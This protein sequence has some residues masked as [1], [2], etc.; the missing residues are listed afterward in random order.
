MNPYKL[1]PESYGDKNLNAYFENIFLKKIEMKRFEPHI[2]SFMM[3][4]LSQLE[5]SEKT[6]VVSI[7]GES[8]SGKT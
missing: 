4:I 1:I 3:N 8:G 5:D 7:S 2:Y 6:Q